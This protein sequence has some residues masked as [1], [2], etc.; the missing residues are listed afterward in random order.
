M[1]KSLIAL[2]LF[3]NLA[4]ADITA[5]LQYIGTITLGGMI[6]TAIKDYEQSRKPKQ[7]ENVQV[8]PSNASPPLFKKCELR[9]VNVNG[10]IVTNQYCY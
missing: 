6:T 4:Y 9:S 8:I 1:K 5:N 3:S 10:Q 7:P 2:L